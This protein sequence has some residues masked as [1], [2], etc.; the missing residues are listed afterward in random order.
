MSAMH[1]RA[2]L[3]QWRQR[4]RDRRELASLGDTM[5]HDIGITRAEAQYLV[6][7]PFWKE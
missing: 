2:T 3:R 1:L 6:N 7:K 4:V 5:L